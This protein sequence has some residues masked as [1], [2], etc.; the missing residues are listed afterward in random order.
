MGWNEDR[1]TVTRAFEDWKRTDRQ[2]RAFLKL[3]MTWSK[4]AYQATWDQAEDDFASVFDPDYDDPADHVN[5]FHDRVDGLWPHDYEWM[6]YASAMKDAVSAFDIFMEMSLNE[7]LTIFSYPQEDGQ[8]I[9]LRLKKT[10]KQESPGWGVIRDA[11]SVFGNDIDSPTVKY[12]RDLRHLLTHQR[13]EL[14]T[15]AA[16]V[17]FDYQPAGA[18]ERI[19]PSHRVELDGARVLHCLDELAAVVRAADPALHRIAW[20]RHLPPAEELLNAGCVMTVPI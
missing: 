9:Q 5:W 13:G 1:G 15:E 11:H 4:R 7:V 12:I 10:G 20:G 3:S 6:L 16:R 19:F 14:H 18:P 17:R 8:K 2:I